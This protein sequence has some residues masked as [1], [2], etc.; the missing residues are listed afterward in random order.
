MLLSP[1]NLKCGWTPIG[2]RVYLTVYR[3][4]GEMFYFKSTLNLKIV[5]LFSQN[6]FAS[7]KNLQNF[8]Q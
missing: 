1:W 5:K 4:G 8:Q 3:F 2:K 7:E 6:I